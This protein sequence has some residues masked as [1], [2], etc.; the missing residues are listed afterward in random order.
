MT[1]TP[2]TE[3]RPATD[4]EVGHEQVLT[5]LQAEMEALATILPGAGVVAAAVAAMVPVP[6]ADD[7]TFEAG[8]DNLPV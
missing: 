8:F 2:K 5:D 3:D 7:E 6:P 1:G 4:A